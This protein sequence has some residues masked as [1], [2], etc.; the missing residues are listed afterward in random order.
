MLKVREYFLFDPRE[1]TLAG[2]SL[3]GFRLVQGEYQ[4]IPKA[5]ERLVSEVLGLHLEPSG[6]QLRLYDPGR[7]AYLPTP[8]EIRAAL[9]REAALRLAAEEQAQR[10]ATLR[11]AAEA[12]VEGYGASSR[13][14]AASRPQGLEARKRGSGTAVSLGTSRDARR[15]AETLSVPSSATQWGG[16]AAVEAASIR[17]EAFSP[18]AVASSR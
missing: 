3:A 7:D 8:A 16:K 11:L 6:E 4:F 13:P 14:S 9:E 2:A 5:G 1:R 18:R 17:V 15:T 12:E 10:E